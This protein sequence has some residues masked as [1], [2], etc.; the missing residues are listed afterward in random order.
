[1]TLTDRLNQ[2]QS[3]RQTGSLVTD[4]GEY[5]WERKHT[6]PFTRTTG[7]LSLGGETELETLARELSLSRNDLAAAIGMSGPM[8]DRWLKGIVSASGA[9]ADRLDALRDIHRR[10]YANFQA[11]QVLDWLRTP[12]AELGFSSPSYALS[13]G[14]IARVSLAIDEL[15]GYR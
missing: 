1:M 14:Q 4:P 6:S 3:D 15:E 12:N 8:M 9:T 2:A 5:S 13:K 11:Y 7:S 10:L